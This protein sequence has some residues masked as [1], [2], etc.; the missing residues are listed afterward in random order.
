[1]EDTLKRRLCK[2]FTL[3]TLLFLSS[4]SVFINT[5]KIEEK[6]DAAFE[7]KN[8]DEFNELYS[9]LEDADSKKAEVYLEK[10]KEH[11]YFKNP[12]AN[13]NTI[14]NIEKKIPVLSDFSNYLYTVTES[15][16]DLKRVLNE[17][18]K[19][20]TFYTIMAMDTLD[21]TKAAE[22]VLDVSL[23]EINTNLIT[24]DD[25][26]APTSFKSKH[27]KLVQSL[28]E[29]SQKLEQQYMF[30][31]L[32]GPDIVS[33]YELTLKGNYYSLSL[34]NNLE[35]EFQQNQTELE[36]AS[37]NLSQRISTLSTDLGINPI[38]F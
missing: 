15:L 23:S 25:L 18:E 17:V 16:P 9:K 30:F 35:E 13:M 26:N 21:K 31:S 20:G 29:Y 5:D 6:A 11:K 27:R 8:F 37:K 24:L 10:I 32:N 1:L 7:Q 22:D 12:E 33:S 28:E 36:L 3:S 4:C 19:N 2:I 34:L 14:R 38:L